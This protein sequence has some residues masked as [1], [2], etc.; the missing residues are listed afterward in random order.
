MC[1]GHA[2]VDTC[3]EAAQNA[4]ECNTL[5]GDSHNEP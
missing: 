5:G 1:A 4:G 3:R 2:V